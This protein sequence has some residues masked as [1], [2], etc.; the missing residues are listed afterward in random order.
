MAIRVKEIMNREV[1]VAKISDRVGAVVRELQRFGIHGAPVVDGAKKAVGTISFSDVID[2]NWSESVSQYMSSPPFVVH[3]E[4]TV[5]EAARYLSETGFHRLPVVDDLTV[6]GNVSALDI[7]RAL[8][9]LPARH[10]WTF[11]HYDKATGLVW[12][13]DHELNGSEVE[14]A[15]DGPGVFLILQGGVDRPET[16]VWGESSDNVRDRLVKLFSEPQGGP[17]FSSY[18]AGREGVRFRAARL[19]D[20][21]KREEVLAQ[22]IQQST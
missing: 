22:V 8:E 5:R 16:I 9:G 17:L 18:W 14:A 7:L 19:L 6:V 1:Y 15:P 4:T 21:D 12:T 3:P 13:E 20:P 10:P 11:P 2:A